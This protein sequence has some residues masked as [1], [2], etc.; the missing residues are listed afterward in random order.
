[1]NDNEEQ[2]KMKKFLMYYY[3]R[4]MVN[5]YKKNLGVIEDLLYEHKAFIEKLKKDLPE[6]H[7]NNINY[8]DDQK[9][10]HL[11]KKI[12]DAGNEAIRDFEKHIECLDI[13]LK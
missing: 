7:L 10:N 3:H 8:F 12:L 11:R 4:S 2:E 9:Y 5:I 6:E 13:K 1:M